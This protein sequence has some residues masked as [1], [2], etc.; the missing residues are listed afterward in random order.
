MRPILLVMMQFDLLG[1]ERDRR[2]APAEADIGV[3]TFGLG[4]FPD[5]LHERK[6]FAEVAESKRAFDTGTLA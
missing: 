6:C 2:V 5:P 1:A 3:M 4:E